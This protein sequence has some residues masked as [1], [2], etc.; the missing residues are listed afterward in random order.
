MPGG[1]VGLEIRRPAPKSRE[2]ALRRLIQRTLNA[3]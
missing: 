2:A 3:I 1:P